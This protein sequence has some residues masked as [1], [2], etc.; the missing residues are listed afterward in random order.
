M[1]ITVEAETLQDAF[2]ILSSGPEQDFDYKLRV[3]T[4]DYGR[5][6]GPE[7]ITWAMRDDPREMK[8]ANM[9]AALR[10]I[11]ERHDAFV[12]KK[13]RVAG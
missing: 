2:H 5:S 6:Y 7:V 10:Y 1:G 4:G 3:F 8:H 9:A 13:Q 12:A 11:A